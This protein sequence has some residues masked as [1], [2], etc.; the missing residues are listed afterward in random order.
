MITLSDILSQMYDAFFP[1]FP[2]IFLFYGTFF[3]DNY[4]VFE[5]SRMRNTRFLSNFSNNFHEISDFLGKIGVFF[6]GFHENSVIFHE[7]KK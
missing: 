5:L 7:K 2:R 4:P 3:E 6:V 1:V